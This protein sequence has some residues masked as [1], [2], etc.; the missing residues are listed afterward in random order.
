[1]LEVTPERLHLLVCRKDDDRCCE[2]VANNLS[3]VPLLLLYGEEPG[4]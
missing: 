3:F 2:K 1:M 4:E